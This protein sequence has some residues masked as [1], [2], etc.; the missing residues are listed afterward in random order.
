MTDRRYFIC[1]V[2]R[3]DAINYFRSATNSA[4]TTGGIAARLIPPSAAP[5]S[6]SGNIFVSI[7]SEIATACNF[8]IYHHVTAYTSQ[9]RAASP[10]LRS[11]ASRII[12]PMFNHFAALDGFVWEPPLPSDSKYFNIGNY[13]RSDMTN[14]WVFLSLPAC[15][16]I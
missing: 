10:A 9:P 3:N 5:T 7:I 8:K 6:A 15:I 2:T 11:A 1:I 16:H 12:T 13:S 14:W 4:N